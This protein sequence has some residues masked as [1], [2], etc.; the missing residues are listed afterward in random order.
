[1]P[2][3]EGDRLY[4]RGAYDMKA[5]L[6]AMMCALHDLALQDRVRVH[7]VCVADEESEESE[8]RGS[9]YLVEQGYLGDFA[10]TGEPTDLRSASR[11]RACW[12][13]AWRSRAPRHTARHHG[14]ATTP[15]SR[16]F[17]VF[18]RSRAS[19]SRASR[20][21]CSTGRRSTS[22]GS[23]AATRSTRCPTC[24]PST[25]TCA[26]CRART[27]EA[28][29]AASR[30]LPDT[31]VVKTFHRRPAIVERDNPFVQTLGEAI[32]RVAAP[33]SERLSVWARRRLGRDLVPRGR[34]ARRGVRPNR[35]RPSWPRGVDFGPVAGPVSGGARGVRHTSP[36]SPA[37]RRRG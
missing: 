31:S 35:G 23:W 4:G 6:A 18:R 7:F 22:A 13:C 30:T 28:I 37:R 10:I 27:R 16:R 14:S 11:P 19:R 8:Q 5:G 26:T 29:Q 25:W 17:D 36:G 15:C 2:R 3:V 33:K 21:S 12:P 34:R 1:M 9:D 20:P 24:A 32:S